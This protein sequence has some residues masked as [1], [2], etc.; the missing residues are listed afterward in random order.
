MGFIIHYFIK[1]KMWGLRGHR[2]VFIFEES[3]KFMPRG[4]EGSV[5]YYDCSIRG[6]NQCEKEAIKVCFVI[7]IL[8]NRVWKYIGCIIFGVYLW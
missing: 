2:W 5:L 8:E 4:L 3:D 7:F 1:S 6:E